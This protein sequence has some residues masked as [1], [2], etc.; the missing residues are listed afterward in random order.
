MEKLLARLPV[1]PQ[2]LLVRWVA[3]TAVM[4]V[5]IAF[6]LA[7]AV[8]TGLSALFILLIGIFVSSIVFDRWS[9][10]YATLL[11]TV[12]SYLTIQYL[13][14][15]VSG[16]LT[17]AV[18]FGVGVALSIVSE[19]LRLA[20]ERAVKA[21][22]EK[23]ILFRE[24]SHR[25]QNNLAMAVSLLNMQ[26]R[27][28]ASPE[29]R[30]ALLKAV[31][32]LNILA[33]GQRHLQ[34]QSTGTVEMQAY[35]GQVCGNLSRSVGAAHAVDFTFKIEPMSLA[36]DRALVIGLVTNE[37]VTNALKY[38]FSRDRKGTVTVAFSRN[39][40]GDLEL[41]V[42]DDGLGCPDD[43]VDGFGSK[44]IRGLVAQHGGQSVRHKGNPG[45]RVHVLI[46][47]A[48]SGLRF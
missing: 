35:L 25:M 4:A 17:L 37:L 15:T 48:R 22:R 2:S 43:A 13:H 30:A 36:A 14:P 26:G 47:E 45:C 7:V 21:E 20:L 24:L 28:H 18:F 5:C 42:D 11:A 1:G 23:D 38:A 27:S 41:I 12:S 46:P 6:Q 31:D 19:A 32:R 34:L 40:A 10:F 44:L 29:V 9:G 3:T 33:E 39:S 16:T 8:F